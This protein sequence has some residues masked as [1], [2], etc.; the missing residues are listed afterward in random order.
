MR[1]ELEATAR[2]ETEAKMKAEAASKA[3]ADSE[4]KVRADAEAKIKAARDAAVRTAAEAKAK[5]DAEAR[6]GREEAEKAKRESEDLKQRL[7]EERKA[8]EDAERKAKDES[9]RARKELEEERKRL[10]EKERKDEEERAERRKREEEEEKARRKQR[11]EE[12][13]KADE[14]RAERRKREE[15]EEKA[16]KKKKE[17]ER[18]RREEEERKAEEE[19]AA[20]RKR[21]EEEEERQAEEERAARRKKRE[22]EEARAREEE[23][24]QAARRKREQEELRQK[25]AEE[26]EAERQRLAAEEADQRKSSAQKSIA[27]SQG[28]KPAAPGSGGAGFDSLLADLDSFGKKDDQ[29][30]KAKEEADRKAKEAARRAQEEALRE[31]EEE[32]HKAA[33]E[34]AARRKREA[35]EEEA[36]AEEERAARRKKR[37][38][39]DRREEE[40][41]KAEQKKR[42]EAEE[43]EKKSKRKKKDDDIPVSDDDLGMDDV[44]R[45]QRAMAGRKKERAYVAPPPVAP[46]TRRRPTNWG[47]PVTLGLIVL[48][49]V[50]LGAVHVMPLGTAEYERAASEAIG[51]PVKIASGRMWLFT[52]LQLK[53]QGVTVG[54]NVKIA[55]VTAFPTFDTLSGDKKTFTRIDLEGIALP[56]EALSEL[57]F[58]K[59]KSDK[60]SVARVVAKQLELTGPIALPKGLEADV[61]LGA[62]GALQSVTVRGPDTLVAKLSPK[63]ASVEFDVDAGGFVVPFAS[64]MTLGNFGMKG[65][66]TRQGMTISEWDGT[67]LNGKISGTANVRWGSTWTVDGVMTARGLNAAVFAP[68]LVS[69]G[70]GEGTA[71]FSLSGPDPAKLGAAGRY[72]GSFK[73]ETGALGSVDLSRALRTG[74]RETAGRTEFTD[75]TGQATYDRGAVTLRNVQLSRSSLNAGI[76]ADIARDGALSGRIVA[77]VRAGSQTLRAT[78]TMGGTSKD[79]Q[80]RN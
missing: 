8:R 62:D 16:Q 46:S 23:E 60:F 1:A 52:G 41:R 19:R 30:A 26:E 13:R 36:K 21:E 28:A 51:R 37:E 11:E 5:A 10:E 29:D 3:K 61:A 27:E 44:K 14:E 32:E 71:K 63:D 4:A 76:S 15:E 18:K 65:T 72:D 17:E 9:E 49:A 47:K 55:N 73:I 20:R 6:R 22:E 59:V 38:E 40:E 64:E 58:A 75:L 12:E 42:D 35:E 78:L 25:Q 70:R 74:G 39:E 69:E 48:L 57:L 2:V 80:F 43:A 31:R 50:A 53:L 33:E 67:M 24:E 68:A 56:Q 54:D 79:P 34:R 45:D 7:E 66:A 77:D